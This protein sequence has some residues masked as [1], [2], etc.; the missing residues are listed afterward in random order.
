M[1]QQLLDILPKHWNVFI[2]NGDARPV[3][4]AL[5]KQIRKLSPNL[6]QASDTKPILVSAGYIVKPK[7]RHKNGRND[8]C[9][10]SPNSKNITQ[11]QPV[12]NLQAP[13]VQPVQMASTEGITA[14]GSND[15]VMFQSTANLVTSITV[16]IQNGT[17]QSDIAEKIN[18][19]VILHSIANLV[20]PIALRIQK[21]SNEPEFTHLYSSKSYVQLKLKSAHGKVFDEVVYKYLSM[22]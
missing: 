7:P 17:I 8:I 21:A 16:P 15:T 13:I 20:N 4:T 3:T 14:T 22:T 1:E 12:E 19:T 6:D 9:S 18:D 2:I 5:R 10:G 11:L